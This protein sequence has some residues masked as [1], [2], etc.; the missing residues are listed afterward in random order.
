MRRRAS[1]TP[2]TLTLRRGAATPH[3]HT[4]GRTADSQAGPEGLQNMRNQTVH[5][6][7]LILRDLGRP[8]RTP[9]ETPDWTGP[10]VSIPVG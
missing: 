9:F 10:V 2:L 8:Q 1:A 5:F 7:Q 4:A 6:Q 3:D